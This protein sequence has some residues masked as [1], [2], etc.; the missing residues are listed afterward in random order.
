LP[1]NATKKV[2]TTGDTNT[3]RK[4]SQLNLAVGD[5]ESFVSA[6]SGGRF[7]LSGFIC[8]NTT[9]REAEM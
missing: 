8:R 3:P 7:E 1:S 9:Q 2:K 5:D 4:S 6:E